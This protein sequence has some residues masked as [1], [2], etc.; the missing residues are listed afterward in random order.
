LIKLIP[1]ITLDMM[2]EAQARNI[3]P[4]MSSRLA[5][6]YCAGQIAAR[7]ATPANVHAAGS[8]SIASGPTSRQIMLQI[9][10]EMLRGL[11][12]PPAPP[13][14][15]LDEARIRV[16]HSIAVSEAARIHGKDDF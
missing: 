6:R 1:I 7:N 4:V 11:T 8:G 9:S 3:N 2:A 14:S 15:S 5:A 10:P 13:L 12:P 16:A